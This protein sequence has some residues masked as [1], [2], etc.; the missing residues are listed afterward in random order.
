MFLSDATSREN[1]SLRKEIA[2]RGE[3]HTDCKQAKTAI[4]VMGLIRQN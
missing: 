3:D 2:Q 4:S 1:A